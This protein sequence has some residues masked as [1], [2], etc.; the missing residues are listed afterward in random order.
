MESKE[1]ILKQEV[2]KFY[3]DEEHMTQLSSVLLRQS[4]S[5]RII[6]Y[7]VTSYSKIFNT[8]YLVDGKNF[9]VFIQ[10]KSVLKGFSKKYFDV[11]A[12]RER[13][14]I[15]SRTHNKHISSTTAQL[16]FFKWAIENDILKY[17]QRNLQEIEEHMIMTL[18]SKRNRDDISTGKK[19]TTRA[20]IMKGVTK[21]KVLISLTFE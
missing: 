19:Q 6:D 3:E 7:F 10:Y 12:R 16:H 15:F 11:F 18:Q 13:I 2:L 14:E 17:C 1:H 20:S 9:N 21:T 4:I 5:L 8:T